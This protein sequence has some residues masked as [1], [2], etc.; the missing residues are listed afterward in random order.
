[1]PLQSL[2]F[3]FSALLVTILLYERRNGTATQP[4]ISPSES[5]EAGEEDEPEN[6]KQAGS[7]MWTCPH[8]ETFMC[9]EL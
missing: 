1:M 6:G 8:L 4:S 3:S 9:L 5:T 2:R 7:E